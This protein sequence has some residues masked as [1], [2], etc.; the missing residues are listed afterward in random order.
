MTLP[1]AAISWLLSWQLPHQTL[2]LVTAAALAALAVFVSYW[3]LWQIRRRFLNA[4]VEAQ[5]K[6]VLITG[7][8]SMPASMT[9]CMSKHA[10]TSLA[11]SLRRQYYDRGVHISTVEPGAYRTPMANHDTMAETLRKDLSLLP[12]RVRSGISDHSLGSLRKSSDVLYSSIMRDD[13]QE[14]VNVMKSAVR[15]LVPKVY[16]RAGGLEDIL[17]RRLY[18]VVP[19]EVTDEV[20]HMIR[21]VARA[22]RRKA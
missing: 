16:Y 11:D 3:T 22:A 10:S 20:V 6:S 7:R 18:E 9:Y 5:G 15:D 17:L 19:A 4:P 1:T 13:S 2:E 14:A 8:M 21:K 12:A